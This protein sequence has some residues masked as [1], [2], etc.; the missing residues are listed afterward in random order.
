MTNVHFLRKIR[1]RVVDQDT[2]TRNS[3]NTQ[4]FIVS[5][6]CKAG[7]DEISVQGDVDESGA[8]DLQL[9]DILQ[10]GTGIDH[11]LRELARILAEF[12][13]RAHDAVCLVVA[14]L[15]FASLPD[16]RR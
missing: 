12:L 1:R 6:L 2:F 8:G 4:S 15:G 16:D 3:G 10:S 14:K 13:C 11:L 7:S 9:S 5:H